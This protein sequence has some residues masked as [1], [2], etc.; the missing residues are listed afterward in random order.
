MTNTVWE[1]FSRFHVA[2]VTKRLLYVEFKVFR[3]KRKRKLGVQ[4]GQK[5]LL[6]VFGFG[7]RHGSLCHDTVQRLQGIPGSQQ[8]FSSPMIELGA[9]DM[10]VRGGLE[11]ARDRSVRL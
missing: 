5:G 6:P 4:D 11:C 8:G 9:H 1:G 7:S 10:R 3:K 2:F